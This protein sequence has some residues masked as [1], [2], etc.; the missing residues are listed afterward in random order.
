VFVGPAAEVQPFPKL[1][2]GVIVTPACDDAV[3]TIKS[4]PVLSNGAVVSEVIDVPPT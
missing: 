4:A 2:E 3:I 1:S